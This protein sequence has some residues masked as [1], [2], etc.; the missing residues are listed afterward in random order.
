M[1]ALVSSSVDFAALV[2]AII[3]IA[4]IINSNARWFRLALL[5]VIIFFI[6]AALNGY[7]ALLTCRDS[8]W[9]QAYTVRVL[10]ILIAAI[11]GLSF[12]IYKKGVVANHLELFASAGRI[13]PFTVLL[14]VF[15]DPLIIP[16]VVFL[17]GI[18]AIL[19]LLFMSLRNVI[20]NL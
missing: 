11:Y 19:V 4:S 8:C 13:M 16:A 9:G 20:L 15:A 12:A 5:V 14:L 10:V 17:G 2:V 3:G 1:I 7:W 18:I 6:T